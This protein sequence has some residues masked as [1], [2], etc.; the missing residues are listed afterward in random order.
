MEDKIKYKIVDLDNT[1]NLKNFRCENT[2]INNYLHSDS[3]YKH[4]LKL[5]RTK[6]VV[7]NNNNILAFYTM[8]TCEIKVRDECEEIVKLPVYE[9]KYLAVDLKHTGKKIGTNVLRRIISDTEI[10]SQKFGGCYLILHALRDKENW[11]T[12]RGFV[13]ILEEGH[14]DPNTIPLYWNL[15]DEELIDSYFDEEG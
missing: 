10:Y 8:T 4:I 12:D 7:D 14:N 5:N 3:Y 11:Y 2:S 13:H 15:R 9:L 6:L 1:Y